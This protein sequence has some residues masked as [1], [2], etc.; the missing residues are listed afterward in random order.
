MTL[1]IFTAAIVLAQSPLDQL[2]A[3]KHSPPAAAKGQTPGQQGKAAVAAG[4]PD[5]G[6]IR[7]GIPL[8]D[9]Y[10]LLQTA[11]PAAKLGTYPY[12]LPGI[13]KPVLEGFSF[14]VNTQEELVIVD[15]TPPPNQQVVW[16]VRSLLERQ[17]I[18]RA[19]VIASLREKYGK[20]AGTSPLLTDD[21]HIT[22]M[23]WI[24]D[25]QGRP[26]KLPESGPKGVEMLAGCAAMFT[27][28]NQPGSSWFAPSN[29]QRSLANLD[30]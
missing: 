28:S 21:Q 3:Y 19:N 23:W 18:Y 16:K 22:D 5:I 27:D 9:A 2:K 30:R 10:T 8:R 4:P 29:L 24:F 26:A 20:E 14:G 7:L 15:V 11:H 25:E 17:K 12:P 13:A 6:G 1:L